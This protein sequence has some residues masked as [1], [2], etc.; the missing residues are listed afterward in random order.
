MSLQPPFMKFESGSLDSPSVNQPGYQLIKLW[1]HGR[2]YGCFHSGNSFLL[3]GRV[4]PD[5]ISADIIR[6]TEVQYIN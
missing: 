4:N 1:S 2:Y 5:W 6:F 3:N